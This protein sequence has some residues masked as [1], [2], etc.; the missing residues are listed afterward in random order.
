MRA[1]EEAVAI[2]EWSIASSFSMVA[3]ANTDPLAPEMP[4]TTGRFVSFDDPDGNSWT[5]QELPDYGA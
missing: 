2:T 1:A 5:L 3:R 4:K